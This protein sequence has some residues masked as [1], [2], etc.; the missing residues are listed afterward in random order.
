[1]SHD[2]AGDGTDGKDGLGKHNRSGFMN[3][4]VNRKQDLLLACF[5]FGE[6]RQ[7]SPRE[8]EDW[9]EVEVHKYRDRQAKKNAT[10]K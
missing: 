5:G 4:G 1:V 3:I 7:M 9:A 10:K 8:L 6:K 2:G